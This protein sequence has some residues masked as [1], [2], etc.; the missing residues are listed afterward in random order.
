MASKSNVEFRVGVIILIGLIILL[1]SLYWLQGYKLER[2]AQRIQVRFGDV[3]SLSVGDNVTVSGVLKGKVNRLTLD[4]AGVLVDLL[5]YQDVHLKRDARITIKNLGLM[6]ER[7]VAIS[8]GKDSLPFDMTAVAPGYYDTGIPE[9]LGM[10][11]DM[12]TELHSLVVA[13]KRTVASDS[14]LQKFNNTVANLEQVSKSL[15]AYMARNESRLD[16]TA[17]NFL[18]ASRGV[19]QLLSRNTPVVDSSMAR[20]D[21]M[22]VRM[23]TFVMRLDTLSQ[24]AKRFADALDTEDGTARLLLE[25]RALYDDLR[26]A[27]G[28]LDDLVNDIRTN[29]RKYINLQ[30]K[31]F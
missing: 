3:G 9:V 24:S 23:E 25:D 19:Q 21:R 1:A 14:S 22:S 5:V 6:G 4:P 26:R 17:Q 2:N 18:G 13:F 31:V 12:I 11:G 10:M 20:I 7:F 30:I 8:P 28:N 15:S 16:E 27:A 29:P